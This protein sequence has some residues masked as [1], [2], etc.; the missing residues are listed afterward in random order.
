MKEVALQIVMVQAITKW[1]INKKSITA[2]VKPLLLYSNYLQASSY[3]INYV[4]TKCCNSQPQT[5]WKDREMVQRAWGKR[6]RSHLTKQVSKKIKYSS[7]KSLGAD[8]KS[9]C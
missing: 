7:S 4:S 1:N 5:S 6:E 9:V 2:S 3:L 8:R